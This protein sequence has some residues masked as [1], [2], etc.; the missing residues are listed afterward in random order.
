MENQIKKLHL[1]GSRKREVALLTSKIEVISKSEVE[2]MWGL[3]T[4][5]NNRIFFSSEIIDRIT[6]G[7][8]DKYF[9]IW[10][11]GISLE[12]Q[13]KKRVVNFEVRLKP[14]IRGVNNDS[15]YYLI[16]LERKS[17]E[18]IT[19]KEQKERDLIPN[20]WREANIGEVT[21]III[22][23]KKILRINIYEKKWNACCYFEKTPKNSRHNIIKND[24][25][26][27]IAKTIGE[28]QEKNELEEITNTITIYC[29]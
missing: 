24:S 11:S 26:K 6:N 23:M 2:K 27:I 10:L 25:G 29:G 9:I 20:N 13:I 22:I 15:G 28:K 12:E 18:G 4:K 14:E 5:E 8:G 19:P 21:E 17:L 16:K 3:T 7:N 1:D